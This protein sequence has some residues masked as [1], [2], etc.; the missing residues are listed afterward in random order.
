MNNHNDQDDVIEQNLREA[1]GQIQFRDEW[2]ERVLCR[3]ARESDQISALATSNASK[4]SPGSSLKLWIGRGTLVLAATIVLAAVGVY[5]LAS[6]AQR[7]VPG[8][9]VDSEI[10]KRITRPAVETP[11]LQEASFSLTENR[12][13]NDTVTA[14]PGYLAAKLTDDPDYE[15]YM[16]LPQSNVNQF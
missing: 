11:E 16:V 15:I 5:W 13:Q 8:N 4:S 10:A 3:I 14:T 1:Y 7:S 6:N 12:Q 2:A 9:S